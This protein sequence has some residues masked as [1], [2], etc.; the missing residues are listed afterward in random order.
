MSEP[1]LSPS[2]FLEVVRSTPLVSIDLIL[3]NP[4][5]E[6][7][8]GQRINQP[9]RGYWFVPGGRIR[10]NERLAEAFRRLARE[11]VGQALELSDARFLGV[12]EHFYDTN[13]AGAAGV[14]THYVVLGYQIQLAEPPAHLPGDQHHAYRWWSV[15]QLLADENV[16]ANTKRYFSTD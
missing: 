6:V 8:L 4:A 3:R 7:L 14:S 10:K 13:F 11:E 12:F 5:G 16:H 1:L 2:S 15:E 9:A